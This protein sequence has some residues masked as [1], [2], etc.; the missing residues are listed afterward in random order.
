MEYLSVS[1]IL[2]N[3]S[4]IWQAVAFVFVKIWWLTIPVVLI[5][6]YS[7]WLVNKRL[8]FIDSINYVY[9][10][11]IVPPENDKDPFSMEQVFAGLYAILSSPNF[12][13]NYFKGEV[14][15]Y[16]SLEI[17][18]INGN[19]RF[20]IRTPD[21]YRDLVEAN[22]YAQY[23]EAE[24]T[25]VEDYTKFAP[26][27]FPNDKYEMYGH[28]FILTQKDAY[29]IRTYQ[30]F[31]S[32]IGEKEFIDPV[33][34]LTETLS[35]LSDG[36]QVWLQFIIRPIDDRW[37]K[38][39]EK[40]IAKLVGKKV[41]EKTNL[42][43]RPIKSGIGIWH[44]GLQGVESALGFP[45]AESSDKE[46]LP[47]MVQ[48]MTSGEQEIVEALERNIAKVGFEVKF[49]MVYIARKEIFSKPK[50]VSP[51]MGALN[52]FHTQN[53]N[54]FKTSKKNKAKVDYFKKYRIPPR[55]RRIMRNYKL[56]RIDQGATPFVFNIEELATV[57]HFP[58]TTV[59]SPTIT[60][61]EAKT[62]EPP[63]DLPI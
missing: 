57:F 17:V 20:I 28:D 21:Y 50:S 31:A 40:V 27:T 55:Q 19:I 63:P 60:Y 54:G 7:V 4:E 5:I 18:G 22:V 33:A 34:V 39:G 30:A 11:I 3:F 46:E 58:Y 36:E 29:P 48:Y 8:K 10:A 14:Q 24:I 56:R 16:F 44:K 9:L 35:K 62:K 51:V 32:Q 53:L 15:D 6:I 59:K 41:E 12:V 37:K 45:G 25:E 42:V 47:S 1:D 43:E 38:E 52:L 26:E 49:R 61:T 13:E 2:G 23:P